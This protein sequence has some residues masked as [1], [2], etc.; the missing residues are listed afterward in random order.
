[1]LLY[2]EIWCSPPLADNQGSFLESQGL[3]EADLLAMVDAGRLKFVTTQPEE[4]LDIPFLEAVFEHKAKA[5]LGRRTTAA[6]LVADIV[7]TAELSLLNDPSLFPALGQLS[8]EFALETGVEP[9]DLL[10]S[11]LWPLMGRRGGL[12]GL[13]DR[14]S[15]G[16]PALSLAKVIAALIKAKGGVD[17][18]LEAL[19]FSEAVHIGHTLNATIF[20]PLN[21]RKSY[22]LLKSSIGHLLN[23]HRNFNREF[24]VPWASNER[25]RADGLKI[26]PPVP[27]FEF[28]RKIPIQEIIADSTLGSTRAKGRSLYARLAELPPEARQE[29]IDNLESA[30]R[31]QARRKSGTMVDVDALGAVASLFT[32]VFLPPLALVK[33]VTEKL[34]QK[35]QI[36]Q[37]ITQLESTF[38]IGKGNQELDFLSRINR[39][40]TF[41]RERV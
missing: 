35:P 41:R 22:H 14:G 27:L 2:D 24:A 11:L 18:E 17:V 7:Q 16:G 36:D 5:V 8:R 4:R 32:G 3:T 15:K 13:L 38:N 25:R 29:E 40:A 34:R 28:D 26:L 9:N 20:G 10:H 19:L 21:E 39:V 12:Q 23:F 31:E 30:L 1:M 33:K 37:M 6:L